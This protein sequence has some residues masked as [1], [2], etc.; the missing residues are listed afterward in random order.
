MG[1]AGILRDAAEAAGRK[2]D[3]AGVPTTTVRYNSMI[4]DFDLLNGL[5][6][7]PQVK[8]HLAQAA[9]EL[10]KYLGAYYLTSCPTHETTTTMLPTSHVAMLA[11]PAKVAA[12][13][14]KAAR[15]TV[16]KQ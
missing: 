5:A 10:K 15:K 1:E 14:M 9:A 7:L 11:Q 12:I 13:I 4:H 3:E 6:G 16:A 8:S 2:L